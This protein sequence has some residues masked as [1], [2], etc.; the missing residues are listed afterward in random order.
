MTLPENHGRLIAPKM[1]VMASNE[2]GDS[3]RSN[4]WT[5]CRTTIGRLDTIL[6]D[7]R[8]YGFTLI[9]GLL[10]ASSF[11][12]YG[13]GNP[14]AGVGAFIAVM[15]LVAGL[16]SVDIYYSVL[17]SAAVERALDLESRAD[18]RLADPPILITATMSRRSLQAK[19]K[20]I[21]LGVYVLLL[22]VAGVLG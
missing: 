14:G 4:E 19:S 18:R 9:S 7:L 11:I 17:Q 6:Q 22:V 5:E 3:A 13:S 12:G 15:C 10:T 20:F 8:K 21:I 16:F 2:N 1:Q